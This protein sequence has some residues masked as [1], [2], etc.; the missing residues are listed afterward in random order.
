MKVALKHLLICHPGTLN[1]PSPPIRTEPDGFTEQRERRCKAGC[2]GMGT[3]RGN[4]PLG[5]TRI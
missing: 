2:A 3:A 4:L 5:P 1:C